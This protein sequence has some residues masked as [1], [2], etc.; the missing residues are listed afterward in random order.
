MVA[1]DQHPRGELLEPWDLPSIT[2]Q[3]KTF[4]R[5]KLGHPF[6]EETANVFRLEPNLMGAFIRVII[7]PLL[8]HGL[9][10]K[11][12]TLYLFGSTIQH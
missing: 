5:R 9:E 2:S 10:V 8:S 1:Q 7:S 11:N 3:L 6:P 12:Q 4:L